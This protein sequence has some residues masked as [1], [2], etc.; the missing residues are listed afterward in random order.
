M[1]ICFYL[2]EIPSSCT[3]L[4]LH[5]LFKNLLN[6][7]SK[8]NFDL[9]FPYS[10]N[11]PHILCN[12]HHIGCVTSDQKSN[13]LLKKGLTKDGS[14]E[15]RTN[16]STHPTPCVLRPTSYVL[17]Q[18]F[19]THVLCPT[20][21]ALQPKSCVLCILSPTSYILHPTLFIL[22]YYVNIQHF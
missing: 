14:L 3:Y 20:S 22:V 17:C 6:P 18:T 8:S 16:A 4:I 19:C 21:C 1:Q 7:N 10:M 5:G 11:L 15:K 9:G 12:H 2:T 13:H